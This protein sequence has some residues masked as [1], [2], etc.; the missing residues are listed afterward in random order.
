MP[1]PVRYSE[2]T[3]FDERTRP[4]DVLVAEI[5]YLHCGYVKFRPAGHHPPT[6]SHILEISGL[7]VD[8]MH[9]RMGVGR[10][11]IDAAVDEGHRRG[12]R[13][14][15][16]RVLGTNERA[17]RLYEKCGFVIEAMLQEEYL[18]DGRY[19]DDLHMTLRLDNYMA[20]TA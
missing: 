8:P 3:F 6:R 7:A 4:Q 5:G 19:V 12:S 9:Q 2:Y 15:S 16:L 18:I 17:R 10:R 13:K 20:A 14:L 1:P 11:L